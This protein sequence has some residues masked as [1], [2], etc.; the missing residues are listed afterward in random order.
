[1]FPLVYTSRDE[2]EILKYKLTETL[3]DLKD[4]ESLR[5]E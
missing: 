4:R 2:K 3:E 5:N 1:M